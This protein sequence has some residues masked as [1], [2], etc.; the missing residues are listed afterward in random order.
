MASQLICVLG[1][2]R[3]K[4]E[5]G[6]EADHAIHFDQVRPGPALRPPPRDSHAYCPMFPTCSCPLLSASKHRAY[7][8]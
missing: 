1:S 5:V 8:L 6:G 4:G 2:C 7:S 3:T